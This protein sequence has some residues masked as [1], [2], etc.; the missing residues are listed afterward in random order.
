MPMTRLYSRLTGGMIFLAFAALPS[1]A[2]FA[3]NVTVQTPF[4]DVDIELFD[5]EAP[6]TVANFLNYV[7]DGDYEDSFIHRSVPGFVVQGGGYIFVDNSPVDIPTDP[8]VINE[9]G[10]SNTRGTVAMAKPNGAPDGATSQWYINVD[11][12]SADL[13]TANGGFTVFGRVT[14]NGMDIIDTINELTTWN[15]DG[16]FTQLPLIDY[17]GSGDVTADHLVMVEINESSTFRINSGLNDAWFNLSTAGQGFLFAVFPDRKEMFVAWFTFDTE[18]PPEDAGAFL[19]EP[20]HRWLTAQGPYDG[21]TA[22]LT[23]YLTEGGVFDSAE[24]AATTD[25]AG[26]GTMTIEF[27]DCTEGLVTYEITSLGISGEIPI[28]RITPDNVALCEELTGQSPD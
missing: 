12:N 15:A 4:G 10:I 24:P 19:G 26:Y 6:Q 8:P 23:I 11:D 2:V 21:D 7:N 16:P 5:E 13:D 28:Q 22:T 3:T 20:G 25:L 17:P 1:G 18:R 27:S 9:P 14:G